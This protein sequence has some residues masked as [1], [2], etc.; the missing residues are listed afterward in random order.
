MKDTGTH[1]YSLFIPSMSQST[2]LWRQ[3]QILLW[4]NVLTK[5]WEPIPLAALCLWCSKIPFDWE[6]WIETLCAYVIVS[7][8]FYHNYAYIELQPTTMTHFSSCQVVFD[9]QLSGCQLEPVKWC[10]LFF[11]LL[12][13]RKWG[14]NKCC[15]KSKE[16]D[17]TYILAGCLLAKDWTPQWPSCSIPQSSSSLDLLNTILMFKLSFSASTS[18]VTLAAQASPHLHW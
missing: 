10:G 4:E 17:T 13:F 11:S 6:L 7:F 3:L 12:H 18:A 5:I 2:N 15:Y 9:R 14:L 1:T 16:K 8:Y